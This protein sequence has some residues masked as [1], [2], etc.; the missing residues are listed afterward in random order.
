[1]KRQ[2]V[3]IL[4]TVVGTGALVPVWAQR[5]RVRATTPEGMARDLGDDLREARGLLDRVLLS[6]RG[7]VRENGGARERET[8][9]EGDSDRRR[10]ELL[11]E[12][13]ERS[14]RDLERELGR[15]RD[16][17]YSQTLDRNRNRQP[18]RDSE[19]DQIVFAIRRA[20]T[21]GEEMRIVRQV[22]ME[23]WVTT[24]Q[25]RELIKVV[26]QP[27]DQEET[28]FLLYTRLTD[29]GRF[30]TIRDVFKDTNSWENV[31]RKLGI[32]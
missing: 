2:T 15:Q 28:A 22:A 10:L 27:R 8:R 19:F 29:S 31:C 20:R 18:L 26:D 12:S 32:R 16:Q 5:E 4:A 7:T 13:S 25:L 14:A 17:G 30:Y 21:A 23:Q 3:L 1:M 6:S 24:G 9:R 11:L